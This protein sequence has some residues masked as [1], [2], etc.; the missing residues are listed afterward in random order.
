MKP[1]KNPKAD[2]NRNSGLYFVIGL[3]MVLFT[4]WRLLELKSYDTINEIAI[5]Y[6]I[7]P[8]LK[9]EVPI[10]ENITATPPQA[11]PSA[12]AI[13]EIVEDAQEVEETIIQSTEM[14][15][16][17]E[18]AAA[19]ISVDEVHVEEVEEEITVPF[20]VIEE[21]PI[22]PGCEQLSKEE[23]RICFQQKIQE[24][25]KNNFKYPP[26]ALEMGIQGR[27][28]VQFVINAQGHISH[29][30]TRG[31]DH[32][33]EKEAERIIACLPRMT[34]GMQR[35]NPVKVPYSIPVTFKLM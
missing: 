22:F 1:K 16:E 7:E 26:M 25:V 6:T 20:S 8:D 5:A 15:Q 24:H 12:P 10:T 21:V 29:I 31:P 13:I 11:P 4:V 14:N 32:L 34:P 30:R 17:T 9:E 28:Y 23:K 18:V 35:G 19:I 3:T 2:L 27:V 33:L